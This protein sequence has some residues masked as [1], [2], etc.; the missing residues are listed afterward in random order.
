MNGKER[1]KLNETFIIIEKCPNCK[2]GD[3]LRDYTIKL[4]SENVQLMCT[5]CEHTYIGDPDYRLMKSLNGLIQ[6]CKCIF[7]YD[8]WRWQGL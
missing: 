1:K 7:H 3:L 6:Q 5:V 4:P 8:V 2:V